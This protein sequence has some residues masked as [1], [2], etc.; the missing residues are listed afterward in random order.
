MSNTPTHTSSVTLEP[1]M[2]LNGKWVILELLGKGGMGEVYRAH[3]L[4]LKRDVAIK[5]VSREFLESISGDEDEI[6]DSLERFHREVQVMAQI[7]H[8]NVL[9]IYDQDS[10][11]IEKDGAQ[12]VVAYLAMEYIP[13]STTLRDT[14]SEEGF[15]PDEARM[16]EWLRNCFLPLLDG[17]E[18]L[19]DLGIVHR[20]L[21]PENI[22]LDAGE[23]KIADFGLARSCRL[24][25]I[26]RSMDVRGTPAYMSSE[27][28]MDPKAADQRADVYALG[29]IL[30]EA[31]TGPMKANQL[32]FRQARLAKAETPF[33]R[34]LDRIIQDA[35]EENRSERLASVKILSGRIR[36]L[37]GTESETK[38]GRS[39]SVA[40][41]GGMFSRSR[42]IW[43]AVAFV[44]MIAAGLAFFTR[45]AHRTPA[46]K[47]PAPKSPLLASGPGEKAAVTSPG[48]SRRGEGARVHGFD[49]DLMHLIPGGVLALP[50]DFGPEQGKS[51]RVAPFYMN[52]ALITNQQYVTFLNALPDRIVVEDMV[53]RGEGRV[54]LLLGEAIKGYEPI[55]F[56]AGRFYVKNALHTA[57]PVVRVTAYGASAYLHYYGLRL[58]TEEEW[59]FVAREQAAT[60]Q[61]SAAHPPP[62]GGEMRRMGDEM[63]GRTAPTQ[64]PP[65]S[66]PELTFP[67]NTPV[68]VFKPNR[69]GIRAVNKNIAEWTVRTGRDEGQE[70]MVMGRLSHALEDGD[71][72]PSGIKR[73][74]WEAFEEVGFRCVVSAD[75]L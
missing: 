73:N 2:V 8:P 10:A 52:E 9:R 53:V 54:W 69:F 18:A 34:R 44:A 56:R 6:A 14:L 17:M 22:L 30:Y 12:I 71:E 75:A 68:T 13:G 31:A 47:A 36:E 61:R 11:L 59:L 16:K 43:L 55:V 19:H 67:V 62:S 4:N 20:D 45:H 60:S 65:L 7:N 28:F 1:G 50:P 70:Y 57:C 5:V 27:H 40:A 49:F 23:P 33:F 74:P 25:P 15:Y 72:T 66:D 51:V 63:M 48:A 26:T 32:P 37:A 41:G 24:K 38:A 64:A 58:P 3:Q 39:P 46:S 21:K 42:R 35:T 29:K